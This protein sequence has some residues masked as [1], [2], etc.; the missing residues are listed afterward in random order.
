M[1]QDRSR[2]AF[3][4]RQPKHWSS[5]QAQQGR[6][7]SDDDW[8]EADAIIQDDTR[9][10]RVHVIGPA[11]SPDDGFR[12]ANPRVAATGAIDF[13]LSPGTLY[14]GGLRATLEAPEAFTLQRDWLQ[15]T[16]AAR[17]AVDVAERIDF[18]YLEVWQQPVTAVE[19][20]ELQEV[21][22]GGPDTSVRV[23]TM[24]RV[25]L[26]PNVATESCA[27]AWASLVAS[28]GGLSAENERLDNA[29]LTIGFVPNAGPATDL[30]SPAAQLGYLGAEN[31]AIRVELGAGN[32]F[33]WGYDNASP[34]YRVQVTTD[35]SGT[36]VI[37]FLSQPKDEQ[38]WPLAQQIVELLPWSAVLPNGTKVAETS[39]GFLA[40]VS[41]SYDPNTQNIQITPAVGASFGNAWQARA[42][43]ASLG[44]SETS[45][46][47]LRAW[48][49]GADTASPI[50]IPFVAGT[51]VALT[52][53]GLQITFG[54]TTFRQGDFW[55]IAARPRSPAKVVPWSLETGR[56]AEGIRR[57]Y[58]P[59][60]IIHW[61]PGGTHTVFD[62]RVTFDPLT[63]PRGCCVTVSP[64]SGWEHTLDE[65]AADDDLCLCF[66]PGDF[67]T[68]RTLVLRNKHVKVHGAG[69]ASRIHGAGLET[70]L[71]FEGCTHVEI[72]DLAIDATATLREGKAAPR[73]HL[74][75][76][77]TTRN[78]DHVAIRGVTARCGSGPV[79]NAA[80]LAIYS[81]LPAS[82]VL[83]SS[84]RVQGCELIVGANQVGLSVIN[85]GHTTIN[86]NVIHVD[87]A[88]NAALPAWWLQDRGFRSSF[89]RTL[90]YRYDL[91]STDSPVPPGATQ[92]R[93]GEIP[94]WIETAPPLARA[95]QAVIDTRRFSPNRIDH[96][97]AGEFLYELAADLIYARGGI[98]Q[99]RFPEFERYFNDMLALRSATTAVR[100]LAAQG[101]VVAGIAAH[102]VRITGNLVR[103]TP[104]GIHVGISTQRVR[105][106]GPGTPV[107]DTA[108]RVVIA[109]NAV[110]LTLMPESVVERHAIF[111]GNCKSLV[112]EDN[113]LEC[114]KLGAASRL[115]IDGIRAYGFLGKMAYITRNDMLGFNTGIR[116][117]PINDAT[118]GPSSMW[119]VI[120]NIASSAN[121]VVDKSLKIGT[122]T[123]VV[124]TGNKA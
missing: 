114:E 14:A 93:L 23:R 53:T 74:S 109:N 30:C 33:L 101:I 16:A 85:Y 1:A 29:T 69:G 48:N 75:G 18:A 87:P 32:T 72:S 66:Q 59:L 46:F 105:N 58:A 103:D 15:Q 116:I 117:A 51:P 97:T 113:H 40:R 12:L 86:D 10:T 98:G 9:H 43:A 17:P 102:D 27:A 104:Q 4:V 96:L 37:H 7:L 64:R 73:P 76:A 28:L 90:I 5:L 57:F 91:V 107:S 8:N 95:W 83:A 68:T 88:E 31:Q 36:Q 112:I 55:I 39:A 78:C 42:D 19:D 99:K 13:D 100:T 119:R 22:L 84:A 45:Y 52:G 38:H 77:I 11:G 120:D 81:T 80:C 60:G 25:R 118:A 41:A 115:P 63:R 47:Y 3:D 50:Q 67:T 26:H 24:R 70:V 20:D 6:L 49:R 56:I 65:H 106:P 82:R 62:C 92:V 94:A 124:D 122:A 110:Y 54:G 79:K 111:T 61:R 121:P 44:T 71:S 108:G 89:R 2:S 34:L 123:N 21:A 35:P